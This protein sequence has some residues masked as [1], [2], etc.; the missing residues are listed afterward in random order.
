MN[1]SHL[2]RFSRFAFGTFDNPL[3]GYPSVSIRYDSGMALRSAA[4]WTPASRVRLDAFGDLA[5]VRVPEDV[6]ARTLPGVG[7]ALETPAPLGWLVSVEWGYGV[8]GVNTG[9]TTGTHVIRLTGYKVF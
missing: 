1:G 8:K 2:D 5:V 7:I 9:G 6:Q 3:R 4:T